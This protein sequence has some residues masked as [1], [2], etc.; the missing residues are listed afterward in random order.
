MS[1]QVVREY[2]LNNQESNLPS[3]DLA[4][5]RYVLQI[6]NEERTIRRKLIIQ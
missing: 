2:I 6:S 1:G 5:G 4:A 3:E